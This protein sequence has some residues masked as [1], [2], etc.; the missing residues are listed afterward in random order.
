ML[1]KKK[2][3]FVVFS[4]SGVVI[5]TNSYILKRRYSF[6]NHFVYVLNSHIGERENLINDFL[7]KHNEG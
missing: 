4:P 3:I 1:C 6:E 7:E 2:S 5:V